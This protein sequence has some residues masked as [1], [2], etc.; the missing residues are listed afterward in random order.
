MIAIE[1][2]TNLTITLTSFRRNGNGWKKGL[3]PFFGNED[4]IDSAACEYAAH[5]E[6]HPISEESNRKLVEQ[7]SK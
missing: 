7:S 3:E 1:P 6:A 2:L 5:L 4:M